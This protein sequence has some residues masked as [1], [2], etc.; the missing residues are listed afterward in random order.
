[1][2]KRF[3][4][5]CRKAAKIHKNIFYAYNLARKLNQQC[6][7][8]SSDYHHFRKT[9]LKRCLTYHKWCIKHNKKLSDMYYSI[10]T[11]NKRK[12]SPEFVFNALKDFKKGHLVDDISH[13]VSSRENIEYAQSC[14]LDFR[15]TPRFEINDD[16]SMK[17]T[18]FG[19]VKED[20]HESTT[21]EKADKS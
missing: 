4:K 15:I 2:N 1:M 7:G 11:R 17:L 18:S 21:K 16:G 13:P 10:Q 8:C 3:R 5:K 20:L 14:V 9:N 19:L 12:Y 6:S